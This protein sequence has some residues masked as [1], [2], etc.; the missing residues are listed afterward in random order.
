MQSLVDT[1]IDFSRFVAL[2]DSIT[3]GYI[4]GG[5]C[6]EGQQSCYAKIL[7]QQFAV[8]GCREFR[9]PEIGPHSVGVGFSGN[10]C[11]VL[12]PAFDSLTLTHKAP[13]G[14]TSVFLQ[15]VYNSQGPFHNMSVPGAKSINLL[16]AG[17]GDPTR[18]SGNF[19]PFFTRMA[20]NFSS[21]SILSD[22]IA[23]KPSFF[24][25]L[26]GNNDA[27]AFA[28]SG[29]TQDQIT[30]ITGPAGV[31]FVESIQLVVKELVSK[32]AAGV[33]AN[34][35]G[36]HA[37]PYFNAIP[38]NALLLDAQ[39]AAELNRSYASNGISFVVGRNPFAIQDPLANSDGV[40]LIKAGELIL[41]DLLLDKEKNSYLIGQKPIP[42]QYVLNLEE[43]IAV[44]N[45]IY[46]YNEAIK[47]VAMENQLAFVDVNTISQ[48]I[49]ADM[50]YDP[51]KK[52]M[53]YRR[54]GIFSLDGLHPTSFGQALLANEFIKAINYRYGTSLAP[55][56]SIQYKGI[57]FP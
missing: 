46:L 2:G 21:S 5:L 30:P 8:L 23:L 14:D 57:Q 37:I 7:A 16:A 6:Y 40:R 35:T 47:T 3:S 29:G 53:V 15:N 45:S 20:S 11:L 42:K 44:Q 12:K 39:E 1:N 13:N 48:Q 22:A 34:L 41:M 19:N 52:S 49:G 54:R 33:M 38:F 26:I 4:D 24:S 17:L 32:G 27:L 18:G 51:E 31:G 10:A 9:Q 55:V 43:K 28:L 36:I 50:W 25:L 56:K